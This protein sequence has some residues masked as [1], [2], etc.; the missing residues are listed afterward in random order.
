[1]AGLKPEEWPQLR[2]VATA[3]EEWKAL[4]GKESEEGSQLAEGSLDE[5]REMALTAPSSAQSLQ[6]WPFL[7]VQG[8][9][10]GRHHRASRRSPPSPL[11][12]A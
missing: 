7:P 2:R 12:P 9:Q 6:A 5:E 8:E 4:L 11:N 1:M 10:S 3:S